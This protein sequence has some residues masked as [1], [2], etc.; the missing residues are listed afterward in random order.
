[1]LLWHKI[2]IELEFRSLSPS[3]S[4]TYALQQIYYPF[5]KLPR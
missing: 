3:E 5:L 2:Q 4:R 1:M